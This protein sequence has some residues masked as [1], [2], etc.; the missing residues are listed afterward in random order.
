MSGRAGFLWTTIPALGTPCSRAWRGGGGWT[1]FGFRTITIERHNASQTRECPTG[2]RGQN[3]RARGD[4]C[5][6]CGSWRTECS[7]EL[8]LYK[9]MHVGETMTRRTE[10]LLSVNRALWGKVSPQLREVKVKDD[11]GTVL[12]KV[13]FDGPISRAD[14]DA[15]AEVGTE[16]VADLPEDNTVRLGD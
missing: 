16:V 9:P 3:S 6:R 4:G 2:R 13:Y 1:F 11:T 10:V 12:I 14:R 5:G 15:M 8:S 7:W